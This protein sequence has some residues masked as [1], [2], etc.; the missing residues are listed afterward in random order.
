MKIFSAGWKFPYEK[1]SVSDPGQEGRSWLLVHQQYSCRSISL[2]YGNVPFSMACSCCLCKCISGSAVVACRTIREVTPSSLPHSHCV[3]I[4]LRQPPASI[5]ER[6]KAAESLWKGARKAP[7]KAL[8]IKRG[9]LHCG[10]C[11][12]ATIRT[13]QAH[14]EA[15][16]TDLDKLLLVE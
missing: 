2:C 1:S 15:T 16:G 4:Y 10:S 8:Q 13:L 9:R 7:A 12:L 11:N 6:E 14:S 5:R 3:L